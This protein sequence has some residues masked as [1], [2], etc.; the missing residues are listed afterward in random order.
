M[1]LRAF[2]GILLAIVVGTAARPTAVHATAITVTTTNDELNAN[3]DC[4]LRE[5][6]KAVDAC[7]ADQ[8]DAIDTIAVPASTAR[9]AT[10]RDQ[11]GVAEARMRAIAAVTRHPCWRRRDGS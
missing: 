5:A 8:S 9:D 4:S 2:L 7:E 1:A 11:I 3:G 6:L 10:F